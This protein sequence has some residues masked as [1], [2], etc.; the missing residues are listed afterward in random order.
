LV[1]R[2]CQSGWQLMLALLVGLSGGFVA[3]YTLLT[4][5]SSTKGR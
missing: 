2:L 5:E 3:R 1:S 4:L